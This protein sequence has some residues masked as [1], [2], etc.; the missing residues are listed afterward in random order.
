[1]CVIPPFERKK[2][3]NE[4]LKVIRLVKWFSL[5]SACCLSMKTR[6][7]FSR[8]HVN[9]DVIMTIYNPM[10]EMGSLDRKLEAEL[11]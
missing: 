11:A 3:E 1:M 5:C 6:V 4:K 9:S 10:V 7:Q 8:A 2:Q